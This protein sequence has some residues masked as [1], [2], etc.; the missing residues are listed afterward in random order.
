MADADRAL[1]APL[2]LAIHGTAELLPDAANEI[3]AVLATPVEV[4]GRVIL[5]DSCVAP[6]V[7]GFVGHAA[8]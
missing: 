5:V 4:A 2:P 3:V 6:V 1:A 8:I 7:D